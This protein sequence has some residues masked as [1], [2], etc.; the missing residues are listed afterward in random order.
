MLIFQ[1]F[2]QI[3]NN[4]ILV[5]YSS[6]SRHMDLKKKIDIVIIA[7]ELCKQGTGGVRKKVTVWTNEA[8]KR[9]A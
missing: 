3:E 2:I 1:Y 4:S 8:P 6:N 7:E 5:W 9:Q